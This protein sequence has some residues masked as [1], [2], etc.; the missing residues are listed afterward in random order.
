MIQVG[1][2]LSDRYEVEEK[3][4]SGGMSIVYKAKDIKLGR[5]VAVK[6]LRDEYCYDDEFV[7]KFKVEAQAAASLSHSNIV[8]IYDVGSDNKNYY[9]VMEFLDGMTLKEH[10]KV[11]GLLSNEET[12]RIGAC[13]ASALECAHNNHIIHRDIKPQNIMITKDGRVKV[14][15]FGIARVATGATI[16]ATDMASGSVHYIPPEQAKSGYS[17]EQSDLYSL[18]ITMYEMITGH[19]P[20][21][22]DSAVSVALKQ[23]HDDLPNMK[24]LNPGIDQNLEQIIIK[25]TMKK[26][27]ARYQTSEDL[28]TDLKRANN[29][30]NEAFVNI[31]RF[32]SNAHTTI[33]NED[34]M[35]Q[36]WSDDEVLEDQNPVVERVVVGAGIVAAIIAVGLLAMFIFNQFKEDIIPVQITVPNIVGMSREQVQTEFDLLGIRYQIAASEYH[37]T[38]EADVILAQSPEPLTV[39]G[40]DAIVQVVVSLGKELHKVPRVE[41][42]E[43]GVAKELLKNAKFKPVQ[44]TDHHDIVPVGAVIGQFPEAGTDMEAGTEVTIVVSL[45]K[46][47]SYVIVPDVRNQPLEA[48]MNV[49]KA[50]GLTVSPNITES[51]NDVVE[52]GNVIAM[53]VLPGETVKEGYEI[54]LT[55]S[56]GKEIKPVTVN[57]EVNDILDIDEETAVLKVLLIQNDVEEIVF[58]ATVAHSDFDTPL[59]IPVTGLGEAKYEVYKDGNFE[60]TYKI[61]FTEEIA[62]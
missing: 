43:A 52:E 44:E 57:I 42:L 40:E 14:A 25:A 61:I 45:G 6:V 27:E 31:D 47:E 34:E 2:I 39:V 5:Y 59:K 9:I 41:N 37:N 10:V 35:R 29:F 54:D 28:L 4:G 50:A 46:K 16:P 17:N 30:P 32:D 8:N 20:F 51:H 60:Y 23:I 18:G 56:L 15:D 38:I 62:E 55:V 36:I 24:E 21:E 49:L 26:V 13:V 22:A 12:M 53:T 1:T 48:A 11:N 7:M 33:L 3:I 58:D 19:V